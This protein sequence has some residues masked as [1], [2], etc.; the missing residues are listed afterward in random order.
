MNEL[1]KTVSN[2]QVATALE[3]CDWAGC[4]IGNK[5]LLRLAVKRLRDAPVSP[6][7]TGECGELVTVGVT[8][9]MPGSSGGFTQAVFRADSVPANVALCLRSQAEK[10][11]AAEIRRERD[12]AAKQLSEVV[13]RMSDDYLTLKADN[14]AKDVRIKE[15]ERE[16]N[17]FC[18][19]LN[20]ERKSHESAH[21][22]AEALKTDNAALTARV[23]EYFSAQSAYDEAVR[24]SGGFGHPKTLKANDPIVIRYREA[25]AALEDKL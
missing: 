9:A 17:D 6:D 16:C 1:E 10:L 2:E 13:D 25:R 20:Q 12:L 15:L 18:A 7:A 21:N 8:G 11:L 23:K 5:M 19:D 4:S 3:K 22:R 14:A 24:P